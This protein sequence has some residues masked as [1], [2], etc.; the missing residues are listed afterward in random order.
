MA[1][2]T[3]E[4]EC[5]IGARALI[6]PGVTV[7]HGSIIAAGAVVTRSIPPNTVAAGIPAR[8]ISTRTEL[9]Q[10]W[11]EDAERATLLDAATYGQF[12]LSEERQAV[13]RGATASGPVFLVGPVTRER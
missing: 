6:M 11:D 4:D 10:R 12:P 9:M 7:G 2:V 1:P 3:V 8:P 5:F 13:L